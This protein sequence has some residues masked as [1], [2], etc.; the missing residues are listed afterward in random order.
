MEEKLDNILD[1]LNENNVKNVEFKE[2]KVIVTLKQ[3]V[4][5]VTVDLIPIPK[6]NDKE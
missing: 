6:N 1:H 4:E 5:T 2:D 3:K